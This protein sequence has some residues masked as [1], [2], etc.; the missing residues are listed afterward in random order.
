MPPLAAVPDLDR[1]LDELYVLPLE[2]FTGARN[3]LARRL[4]RA[5]QAEAAAEVQGLRKPSVVAW[6]ANQLARREPESMGVLLEAGH[7]LQ[8]A[9]ARALGGR[10]GAAEVA[11]A[12]HAEREAVRRLLEA[13]RDVLGDRATPQTLERLRQ[14]LR[15][16]AVEPQARTLLERGRL[17]EEVRTVGFGLL[18]AVQPAPVR[19]EDDR[20]ARQ[21]RLRRLRE[22]ARRLVREAAAAERA[23][24]DA[25]RDARRLRGE[26]EE[27]GRAADEAAAALAA[28]ESGIS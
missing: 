13:G 18:E 26:A 1:E 16:A 9:Q 10:A 7:V 20:R 27:L 28:E 8:S 15:S 6:A 4:K 12:A 17:T 23:A 25:E 14:T 24:D 5:H 2:E 19:R 11:A 21:E 22:E 3:D